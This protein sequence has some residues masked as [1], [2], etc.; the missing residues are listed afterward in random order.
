MKPADLPY[1]PGYENFRADLAKAVSR[2]ETYGNE[3]T[4]TALADCILDA[5]SHLDAGTGVVEGD[6]PNPGNAQANF[7]K[8]LAYTTSKACTFGS[9]ATRDAI[10]GMLQEAVDALGGGTPVEP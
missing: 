6:L 1:V 3:D 4:Q 7:R 2:E 5:I 10:A 9:S 8:V